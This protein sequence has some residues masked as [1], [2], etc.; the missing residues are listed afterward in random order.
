MRGLQRHSSRNRGLGGG[1]WGPR[2]GGTRGSTACWC[3]CQ[4]ADP[5]R[6]Y[7]QRDLRNWGGE[8]PWLHRSQHPFCVLWHRSSDLIPVPALI[9]LLSTYEP[10]LRLPWQPICASFLITC[11][12]DW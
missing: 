4:A 3:G 2:E 1:C 9:P 5:N 12:S 7:T 10:W 6:F 11:K 8:N